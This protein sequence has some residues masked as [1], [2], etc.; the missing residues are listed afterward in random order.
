MKNTN[1][2]YLNTVKT[3]NISGE[4]YDAGKLQEY[5]MISQVAHMYY[6]QGMLQP[7]IA[8]KLFFSRSKV[9]RLLARAKELGIVEVRVQRITE[10]ASSL[11]EKL[12]SLFQ[13]KDAVVITDFGSGDDENALDTVA[14]FGALYVS[15][16]LKSGCVL[17]LS[18]GVSVNKVVRNLIQLQD[19]SLKVVQLLGSASNAY[20]AIES[21]DMVNRITNVFPG[22]Q[23]FFLNAPLY[24]DNN[25]AR[26]QLLKDPAIANTFRMM[27]H[28]DII[29][30][31]LGFFDADAAKAADVIREYRTAAHA[32]ELKEKGAVGCICALYFDINGTYIP[33][34]WNSKCITIPFTDIQE[35]KMTIAVACG[36][37]KV[38]PILGALRG[39]LAD[40]V[41]TDVSTASQVIT[42]HKQKGE[43]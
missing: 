21:R 18:N 42:A 41:I 25:F 37:R 30:T 10:R 6:D 27:K 29:L 12:K 4:N 38:L 19:Y 36:P 9:S 33:C 26:E 32:E 24:M 3:L 28:C 15:G 13:L 43:S 16:L 1:K 31:G 7:D 20:L 17:G 35:N 8:K 39:R 11:E 23:G 2:A 40:V 14:S 34:E 5:A 22:G